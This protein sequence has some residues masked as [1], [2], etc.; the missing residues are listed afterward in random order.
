MRKIVQRIKVVKKSDFS[1]KI[2][3]NSNIRN[4]PGPIHVMCTRRVPIVIV[5]Q[6]VHKLACSRVFVLAAYHVRGPVYEGLGLTISRLRNAR[7]SIRP[8]TISSIIQ[9]SSERTHNCLGSSHFAVHSALEKSLKMLQF[10][11]N[12]SRPLKVLD[13]GLGHCKYL[14]SP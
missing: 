11:L 8:S 4:H 7:V 12:N 13:N 3:V 14:K 6:V 9:L 10:S 2:K 1:S 5:L